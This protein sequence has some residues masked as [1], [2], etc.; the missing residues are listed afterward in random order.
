MAKL[1]Y[2]SFKNNEDL[3]SDEFLMKVIDKLE[4]RWE[5]IAEYHEQYNPE[6]MCKEC[7]GEEFDYHH[8][9]AVCTNCGNEIKKDIAHQEALKIGC[10]S[11][12][13]LSVLKEFFAGELGRKAKESKPTSEQLRNL[14]FSLEEFNEIEYSESEIEYL[15][16]R[17]QQL[18][19][20]IGRGN[21]VDTFMVNQLVVQ[22][23]KIMNMN[24]LGK[25]QDIKS[26]DRK[27]EIEIYDKLVKNLKA[28]RANRDDVEDKTVI[29]ELAEKAKALN[30]EQKVKEH[31]EFLNSDYTEYLKE[32]KK[33]KE[34]VGNPY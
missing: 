14:P 18:L 20:E 24:R 34:E 6:T 30:L 17:Y 12:T 9:K 29:Q 10:A 32:A 27:K 22:E 25:Y 15:N 31:V 4:E 2:F 5:R 7:N 33:R 23:L 21:Y 8:N 1:D 26:S 28:A 11:R 19:D 3:M 16:R 13:F